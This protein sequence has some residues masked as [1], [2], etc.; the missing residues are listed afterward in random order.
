MLFDIRAGFRNGPLPLL[1]VLIL[2]LPLSTSVA[3]TTGSIA[4]TVTDSEGDPVVGASVVV[5]GTEYGAM[6]DANGEYFIQGLNSGEYTLTARMVGM[7]SFTKEGVTVLTDLMTRTDFSLNPVAVGETIIQVTEQRNI[8]LQDVPSTI[9]VI[10]A[11][12]I[13]SMPVAG[14]LDIVNRQAGIVSRGGSIH[15]RGGRAGEVSFLLDGVSL[16]SPVSNSFSSS[17]PLSAISE[18]MV[19]T[20]G[21]GAEYGGAMSGVVSMITTEG[22]DE[23]SGSVRFR[24]GDYIGFTGEDVVHGYSENSENNNFRSDATT[25]E[26]SIGG[27]EPLTEVLLPAIG[28]DIPGEVSLHVAGQFLVCG[29][30]FKDSRGYWDNNWLDDW[31]GLSRLTYRPAATTG[32]SFTSHYTYR[33]K[34]WD[35]WIWSRYHEPI[36]LEG[37]IIGSNPDYALPVRFDEVWGTSGALTQM[38]GEKT[39]LGVRMSFNR[40]DHWRRIRTEEGGYLGEGFAPWDWFAYYIPEERLIDSLGFYHTG[41]HQSVSLD[42]RADVYTGAL[43]FTSMLNPRHQLKVG[44]E[45]RYYDVYDYSVYAPQAGALI[46]SQWDAYPKAGSAWAESRMYFPGG[47]VLVLGA[48][49]DYFDPNCTDFDAEAGSTVDVPASMQFSPRFGITHPVTES[50]VFF[51]TYGHYFQMPTLSQLYLETDYNITGD[52][53]LVGN[54]NL[55][56]ERTTGYEGGLRHLFDHSTSLAMSAFYKD[57][58]GLVRTAEY[59]TEEENYFRY[60]NDNSHGNVKGVELTFTRLPGRF[61]SWSLGYG[62]TTAKGKYSSPEQQYLY[63]QEGFTLPPT[64]DSYLD[65]DQRHTASAHVDINWHRGEGPRMGGYPFLEGT[66]LGVDWT[67]GS[68]FPYSPPSGSSELP[69]VNTERYPSTMRTDLRLSREVWIDP[70]NIRLDV[71][72]FNVF[73][74]R[75]IEWIYDTGIYGSTGYPGG[76]MCN[77]GAWSP[78][79]HL[80]FGAS[81]EW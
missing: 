17:I 24:D 12:E 37:P 54:P 66:G 13:R 7:A 59:I 20:G 23:Y 31:S 21:L 9:H 53:S 56:P 34:G 26:V 33:E 35:E 79:R 75:N 70:L 29:R 67:Y 77:P 18:T 57:I 19:I 4:G 39:I 28:L 8:I 25:V 27:P 48:R 62:Y 40:F 11:S 44:I 81:L 41:I 42:S 49:L 61:L 2:L 10:D 50:D 5:A 80:L 32:I 51:A 45:G 71:T 55:K 43:D 64:E 74:R 6:T 38:L 46:V 60:E 47:M 76:S 78:A 65:W 69:L 63:E 68:G 3:G 1:T 73:N 15:V 22:G 16:R 30:N 14:V 52:V 58:T 36:Y 72:I